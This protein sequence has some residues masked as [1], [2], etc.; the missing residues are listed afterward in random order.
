[1]FTGSPIP[2]SLPP[3]LVAA[4]KADGFV[5]LCQQ[6]QLH[7]GSD[8]RKPVDYR[9]VVVLRA[10]GG[11]LAVLPCTTQVERE[12]EALFRL[13][14]QRVFWTRPNQ[15]ESGAYWR[16]EMIDGRA[17]SLRIGTLTQGARVDLWKWITERY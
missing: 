9:P 5:Q 11:R 3:E 12:P 16:Y 17:A 13:S 1:M 8:R 10:H 6:Q 14:A 15:P 7:F 4:G 2:E